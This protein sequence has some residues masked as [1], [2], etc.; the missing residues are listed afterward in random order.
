MN[1]EYETPPLIKKWIPITLAILAFA[2]AALFA[3][4]EADT[5]RQLTGGIFGIALGAALSFWGIN[6][7]TKGS[8]K[9]RR[10]IVY[11]DENST[12]FYMLVAGKRFVP[13]II[14]FFAGIWFMFK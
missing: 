10:V 7:Y 5:T 12:I 6:E 9:G 13:G 8:I 2:C 3:N 14:M 1:T 4:T 11:R